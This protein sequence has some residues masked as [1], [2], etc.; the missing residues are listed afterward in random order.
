MIKEHLDNLVKYA[1]SERFADEVLLAKKEYQNIAGELFVDDKSYDNRMTAFLEWYT[2]DRPLSNQTIVP[3]ELFIDENRST[4]PAEQLAIYEGFV[5]TIHGI[6]I[7]KKIK[8]E[9]VVI[10]NLFDDNDYTV[11][12]EDGN[13]FFHKK[14]IFE[15]RLLPL[16]DKH[17]FTGIFTYHPQDALKFLKNEAKKIITEKKHSEKTLKTMYSELESIESKL[18]K[19]NAEIEKMKM[20]VEKSGPISTSSSLEF[21]L[22]EQLGKALELEKQRNLL[23]KQITDWNLK[24]LKIACRQSREQ[25]I[26][27][28]AYM[29]LKWERSR[30]IALKDIYKSNA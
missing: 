18:R 10:Y 28:L 4:L 14:D 22:S 7:L 17:Y 3:L 27:R 6:F 12:E 29:N 11:V 8:N 1:T 21:K 15:G 26:Q 25:L 9:Q 13:I 19:A 23:Q 5:N 24:V 20:K 16:S 30:N 2:F